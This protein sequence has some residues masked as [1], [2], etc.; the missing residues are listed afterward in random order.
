[1]SKLYYQSLSN[2]LSVFINTIQRFYD[3][4]IPTSVRFETPGGHHLT[5][6]AHID[7]VTKKANNGLA[8]LRRNFSSCPKEIKAQSYQS[9]VR[10]SLD[11]APAS[12]AAPGTDSNI[13][14]LEIVQRRAARFTMGNSEHPAAQSGNCRP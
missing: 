8:F 5:W 3:V 12:W 10:P 13:H 14:Q 11:Y 1:M 2:C 6:N 9:L 4:D 7:A